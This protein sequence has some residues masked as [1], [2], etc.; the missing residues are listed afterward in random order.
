MTTI[1]ASALTTII[2]GNLSI[3]WLSGYRGPWRLEGVSWI[4]QACTALLRVGNRC[5]KGEHFGGRMNG[6]FSMHDSGSPIQLHLGR[7]MVR[8]LLAR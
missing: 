3:S 8:F 1:I 5:Y 7:G 4:A 6:A 2:D